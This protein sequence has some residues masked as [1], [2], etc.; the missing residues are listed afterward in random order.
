[1]VTCWE[2]AELLARL[3][4]KFVFCHFPMWC[5][6]SSVVLD[7]LDSCSLHSTYFNGYFYRPIRRY[8]NR[9]EKLLLSSLGADNNGY[10]NVVLIV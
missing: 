1:M 7:C 3:F 5:P 10:V 9:N 6:W 8:F 4:L 2:R